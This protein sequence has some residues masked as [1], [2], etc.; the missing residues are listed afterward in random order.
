MRIGVDFD[1]TIVSYDTLFHRLAIS[2][3][4]IPADLPLGKNHIRNYLRQTGQED[5]WTKLQGEVYGAH[6]R[7]AEPFP[8]VMEFFV[9]CR[10][11]GHTLF[12][13]SHKTQFPFLGERHDLHTAAHHWLSAQ[14]FYDS[15]GAGLTP[16]Q[17]F[18]ELT[19]D[20]KLQ[21]IEAL[22]CDAFIDD[23]L[24]FLVRTGFPPR[25][26]RILFDPTGTHGD[27]PNLL[28]AASWSEVEAHLVGL[29]TTTE[30]AEFREA[31][32]ELLAR[33]DIGRLHGLYPL[34]GGNNNRVFRI[35]AT[36][37][38]AL[39][40]VYFRHPSDSRDRLAAEFSFTQYAW[41]HGVHAVPRPLA[42]DAGR[43][44]ALY[45]YIVGQPLTPCDLGLSVLTQCVEFYI[46]LN[47]QRHTA[48]AK[49]LPNASEA[50][51]SLEEHLACVDRRVQ[52][53]SLINNED[54]F[55][56]EALEFSRGELAETWKEIVARAYE[57]VSQQGMSLSETLDPEA[58]RLSPS[59]FGFHNALKT[60]EGSLRFVDFE[61][62]G[63]DD[64]AKMVCDFF[65]SP[66]IP[67]PL[68][69]YN[70]FVTRVLAD[71]AK[72]E[73]Q[74]QRADLLLP[75]YQMKW[76]CILLNEFL[77]VSRDR[78]R[79][80]SDGNITENRL[81]VQLDKARRAIRVFRGV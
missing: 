35:D 27:T 5:S 19:Q 16:N 63:W 49:A 79:F 12:I 2:R 30:T 55:H 9:R 14:G 66:A 6:I 34:R 26:Q 24:E 57:Q 47:S 81:R 37:G 69:Y 78:R 67:V 74:R 68:K 18:F 51:F 4:L 70:H 44:C 3:S 77:P 58:R 76:C 56:E 42:S 73:F 61:Y 59:D 62:A 48:K 50:C 53:L 8:G 46:E 11:Q 32:E 31:A 15:S 65:S 43:G 41:E 71:H 54:H 33:V 25:L 72:P 75:V 23:L 36:R 1:N 45:E 21:R 28:R 13:V 10:E 22:G 29:W 39:L 64:P 52:R 20:A 38:Q 60:A 80:A 17:V 40:K 7:E